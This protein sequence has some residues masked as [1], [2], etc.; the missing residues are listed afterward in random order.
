MRLYRYNDNPHDWTLVVDYQPW[1]GTRSLYVFNDYLLMGDYGVDY[2]GRWDGT[3]FY[4]DHD[5]GG[6]CIYDYKHHGDYVYAA[7]WIG[8][9]WQSSDGINWT[10]AL[11]YDSDL[12]HMW[13][14]ET[15]ANDLY[16][17]YRNG[18]LRASSIPNPTRGTLIY[19]AA[20]EII[21]MTTDGNRLYFGTGGEAGYRGRTTGIATVY[22][23]DD[24][25]VVPISGYDE[26]GAGVQVLYVTG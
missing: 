17:A 7:A 24:L 13:Q 21:S 18:Q 10:L 20:D 9:L 6:S 22:Q 2:F 16:M 26:M 15:F 25:G 4:A 12:G 5:G 1:V 3:N 23:Y 19:T 11:G 8:R 14:L